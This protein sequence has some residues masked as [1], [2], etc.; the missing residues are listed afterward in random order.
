MRNTNSLMT[1]SLA[2]KVR[3]RELVTVGLKALKNNPMNPPERT[4]TNNALL[5]LRNKVRE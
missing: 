4:T 1:S 5:T 3:T 2:K